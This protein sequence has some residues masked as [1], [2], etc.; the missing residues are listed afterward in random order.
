MPQRPGVLEEEAPMDATR[1]SHLRGMAAFVRKELYCLSAAADDL[2]TLSRGAP[3]PDLPPTPWLE[4]QL[5]A[6][7]Q[8]LTSTQAMNSPHLF[9]ASWQLVVRFKDLQ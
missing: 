3:V 2:E 4:G 8:A 9:G 6:P 5:P 7:A 1:A